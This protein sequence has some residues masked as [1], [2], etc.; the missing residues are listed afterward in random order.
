MSGYRAKFNNICNTD[1]GIYG[2]MNIYKHG[3]IYDRL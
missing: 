3:K 1:L 2:I